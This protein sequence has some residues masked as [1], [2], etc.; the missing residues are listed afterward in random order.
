MAMSG[1]DRRTAFVTGVGRGKL[2]KIDWPRSDKT[3][4][5]SV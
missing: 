2:F 1:P 3:A 5:A 4:L